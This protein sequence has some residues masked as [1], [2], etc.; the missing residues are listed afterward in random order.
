ME[1]KKWHATLRYRIIG[2]F[3]LLP[4]LVAFLFAEYV[5]GSSVSNELQLLSYILLF[6]ALVF[7]LFGFRAYRKKYKDLGEVQFRSLAVDMASPE[8]GDYVY[9]FKRWG[10]VVIVWLLFLFTVLLMFF[11]IDILGVDTS[12]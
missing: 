9:K 1:K 4:V 2:F 7:A 5:S 6:I 12:L 8:V 11:D 10:A 3:I